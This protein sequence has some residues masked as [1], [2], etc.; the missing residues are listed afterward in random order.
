LKAAQH[1]L[2]DSRKT[3][4]SWERLIDREIGQD[5]ATSDAPMLTPY[6]VIH[7]PRRKEL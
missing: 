4:Q 7:D 1:K 3:E 2:P 5:P 6:R